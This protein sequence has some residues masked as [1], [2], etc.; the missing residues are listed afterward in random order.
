MGGRREGGKGGEEV[1]VRRGGGGDGEKEGG[2]RERGVRTKGGREGGRELY[3]GGERDDGRNG[4]RQGEIKQCAFVFACQV[5]L[6]DTVHA[7]IFRG[8]GRVCGVSAAWLV[9]VQFLVGLPCGTVV[10]SPEQL[11]VVLR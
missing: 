10:M 2:G 9:P 1:L 4:R 3:R 11:L 6:I 7:G 5:A 8:I